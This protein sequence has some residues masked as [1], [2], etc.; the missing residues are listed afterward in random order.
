MRPWPRLHDFP[1]L[2][3]GKP[4]IDDMLASAVNHKEGEEALKG[5]LGHEFGHNVFGHV[6]QGYQNVV[7]I[8][9]LGQLFS[10][11]SDFG[12]VADDAKSDS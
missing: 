8:I 12:N 1:V 4:L 6:Q 2:N 5:V 9:Q 3:M 10:Q 7:M 11:K